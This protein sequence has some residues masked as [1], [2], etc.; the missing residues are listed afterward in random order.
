MS[1]LSTSVQAAADMIGISR[2]K[3]YALI[4]AGQL[5]TFKIGKRRLVKIDS[6]RILVDQ[7]A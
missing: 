4:N 6:I 7:A 5:D 1:P 3:A 2:T